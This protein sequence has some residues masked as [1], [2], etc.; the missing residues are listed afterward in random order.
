MDGMGQ[1]SATDDIDKIGSAPTI[2]LEITALSVSKTGKDLAVNE[3]LDFKVD[4]R[5]EEI[6]RNSR[7]VVIEFK[8]KVTSDPSIVKFEVGGSATVE[9]EIKDVEKMMVPDSSTQVPALVSEIYSRV[10]S[11]MFILASGLQVS[12][13]A[14]GL[15][16]PDRPK[17]YRTDS[18]DDEYDR[19][20]VRDSS[21]AVSFEG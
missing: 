17:P 7:G 10:Y 9:G 12:Y 19:D 4:A 2:R 14:A 15:L 18:F 8:L 3:P 6:S 16:H 13:P 20:A 1:M 11:L 5:L 21:P